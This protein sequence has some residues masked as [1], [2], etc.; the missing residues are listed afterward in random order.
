MNEP[1]NSKWNI[2][3][4]RALCQQANNEGVRF[5]ES[6]SLKFI[7]ARDYHH[8]NILQKLKEAKEFKELKVL[9]RLDFEIACE[10]DAFM[11]ALNSMFDSLAQLVNECLRSSK[12]P[13]EKVVFHKIKEWMMCQKIYGLRL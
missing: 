3:E 5:A 13:V 6:L 1:L 7:A 9:T 4:F 12:S 11:N 8:K 10:M 2:R